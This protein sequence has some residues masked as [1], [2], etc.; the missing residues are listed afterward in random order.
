MALPSRDVSETFVGRMLGMTSPE[1]EEGLM[2]AAL[3]NRAV[4]NTK[5]PPVW[6]GPGTEGRGHRDMHTGTKAAP[7]GYTPELP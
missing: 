6:S 1:A 2:R 3:A 7:G 5:V 4:R